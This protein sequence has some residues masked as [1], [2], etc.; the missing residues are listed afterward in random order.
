MLEKAARELW[1]ATLMCGVL[2]FG[3]EVVLAYVLPT[4]QT[5]LTEGLRQIEFVRKFLGAM[6][7]VDASGRWDV[8]GFLAFTW[9]HPVVLALVWAHALVCCTRVPAG[10]ID[11]GTAD[12]TLTVPVTRWGILRAETVAWL[13][14]GL[15]VL[16]LGLAGNELGSH[17][18]AAADRPE[19]RRLLI[20]VAN[21]FCLYLAVGGLSWFVSAASSRRGPAMIV[22]FLILLA[23]FLLNFLAPFWSVAERIAFLG[24]LD[25][26]RPIYILRDGTVPWRDM[27]VLVAVAVVLWIAAGIVFNRR[28]VCTV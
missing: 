5:Q 18:V 8:V 19:Q 6:L 14:A 7:G 26:Y 9:V 2:L 25:Y 3:V 17:Y 28:D 1:P 21:L 4:F 16:A 20:V 23:S 10:E 22:V 11:R 15:T 13:A 12:L 27:G 24:I